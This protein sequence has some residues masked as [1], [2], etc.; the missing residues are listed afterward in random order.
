MKIMSSLFLLQ[1]KGFLFSDPLVSLGKHFKRQTELVSEVCP[2]T[3]T[4]FIFLHGFLMDFGVEYLNAQPDNGANV[5]LKKSLLRYIQNGPI[6][7]C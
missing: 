4:F 3:G 5:F 7:L 6:P 2:I 1:T